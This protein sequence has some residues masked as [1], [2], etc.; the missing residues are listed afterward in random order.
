[1]QRLS[2]FGPVFQQFRILSVE[3]KHMNDQLQITSFPQV[4][5]PRVLSFPR[6]ATRSQTPITMNQQFWR[7]CGGTLLVLL[8]LAVATL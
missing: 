5:D 1:M 8:A 3:G 4:A 7:L 6:T 2:L